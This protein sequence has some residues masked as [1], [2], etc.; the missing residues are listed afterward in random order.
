MLKTIFAFFIVFVFG[1]FVGL[2]AAW[3]NH[4]DAKQSKDLSRELE[5]AET[6]REWANAMEQVS[7][8]ESNASATMAPLLQQQHALMKVLLA[9]SK[10]IEQRLL[11]LEEKLAQPGSLVASGDGNTLQPQ[12][13]RSAAGQE[14]NS[15][16]NHD[17]HQAT[18]AYVQQRINAGV[19]TQS[20]AEYVRE[21]SQQL[22]KQQLIE[23][24]IALNEAI[25]DN[26]LTLDFNP[27]ETPMF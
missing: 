17:Q 24:Q 18:L 21:Q 4:D 3:P 13:L 27:I 6:S 11:A 25:N 12:V 2:Y 8:D 23:I 7:L 9:Q 19:W 22:T 15:A 14:L 1:I 5:W 26:R 10:T 16:Q 20:N